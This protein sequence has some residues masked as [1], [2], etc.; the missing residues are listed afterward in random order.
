MAQA[1]LEP[2]TR[3]Q[4][5]VLSNTGP[6]ISVF[7]SSS[8]TLLKQLFAEVRISTVCAEELN[9]HGWE[10]AVQA[11]TPHLVIVR[12]TGEEEEQAREIAAQ[13]AQHP[14]TNDPVIENHLGEA[15]V[16]TLALR[17]EYR[18]DLLLLDE[19]AA[20]AIAKQLGLQ[21]SG[22][23]GVLLLAVQAGLISP[24]E[25]KRRLEQCRLQGTRYGMTFIEQVYKM[26]RQSERR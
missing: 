17:S 12:L 24:E 18:D 6:L 1:E 7:Q 15:Q 23:P 2:Q 9:R 26:A 16:I 14:S 4:P 25:L 8:F 5:Y 21:L 19:L 3:I 11:A 22:F 13:I 10:V 20:R